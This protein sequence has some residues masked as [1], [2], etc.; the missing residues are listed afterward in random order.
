M[1]AVMRQE[2]GSNLLSLWLPCLRLAFHPS[3]CDPLLPP[4]RTATREPSFTL[5]HRLEGN[6][7]L[8]H[9][10]PSGVSVCR[11]EKEGE[12]NADTV[13][14]GAREQ[15]TMI[16]RLPASS[17]RRHHSRVKVLMGEGRER[18]RKGAALAFRTVEAAAA[19]HETQL[20]HPTGAAEFAAFWKESEQNVCLKSR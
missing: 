8:R 1:I 3:L 9:T 5:P 10:L 17:G 14:S 4:S 19:A 7:F 16:S 20:L 13:T 6:R 2:I 18:E 12:K 15:T 11:R